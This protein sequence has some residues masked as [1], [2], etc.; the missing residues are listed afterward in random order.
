MGIL[1]IVIIIFILFGAVV[2]FKR[3]FT[4]E[5]VEA[6][7]F[8]VI[9]VLAYLLK[10]PLSV[11]FYEHLPFFQIGILK[12]VEI[13]NILIYEILAFLVLL[14]ILGLL[15]RVLLMATSVF[16]KILNA[17]VILSLPSKI[18]GAVIGLFQHYIVA[19][20]VLYILTLTC[21]NYEIVNESKYRSKIVDNTPIL[22]GFVDESIKVVDEFKLLKQ[23]YEDKTIS[24]SEFNYSALELFLKYDL[25]KTS[26][27]EKLIEKGKITPFDNYSVLLDKYKGE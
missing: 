11:L 20:I 2:G 18:L 15:L 17:T 27:V 19:F 8:I 14:S 10:N 16:E 4:K 23:K 25:V 6:V 13:L 24:E 5:L 7:G 1:D 21:F 9:V 22:S 26:S 12:G 3:G